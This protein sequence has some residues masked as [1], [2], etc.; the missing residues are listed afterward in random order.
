M[1]TKTKTEVVIPAGRLWPNT[2]WGAPMEIEIFG[3][4]GEFATGKTILGLSIAPGVHPE[5]HPFAGQPRT[6]YLDLEKSGATYQG[7]GCKRIDVPSEMAKVY[8]S[9]YTAK[10]VAEWFNGMPSRI[11]PGQFDVIVVDPINDIESGE[12]DVVRSNPAASGYTKNQFDKSVAI[13][14]AAV[15]AHYKRLLMTFGCKCFF[16]TTHLRDEFKG[17]QPSGKREPRGKET[18]AELASLYLWLERKPDEKG[19]VSDKPS[20]IVLKQRLADTRMNAAGELE[21]VNLM[22]PRIPVATVQSI[23]GYIANPP[24][25]AKLAAG[26]RVIEK[27][28]TEEELCRLRLATA[29]AQTQ[30]ATAQAN[31]L[32]RQRELTAIRQAAQAQAPQQADQTAR[33]NKEASDKREADAIN[34]EA[35]AQLAAQEAEGK[36][37]MEQNQKPAQPID[38]RVERFKQLFPA[39]GVTPEKLKEALALHGV[40]RFSQLTAELQDGLL[41]ALQNAVNAKQPKN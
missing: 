21:I 4:T 22:P 12:V 39:S 18:L 40:E 5:G 33:I 23:R 10:Q 34:A 15:K 25:Y 16:F 29:E 24:D 37:L 35:A 26:E 7:T 31:V 36:R 28:A 3:A 6:L 1:A 32:D 2:P 30:A 20:A 38:D 14:M 8:G 17:G 19:V 13:L 11:K 41:A 9:D 27:S